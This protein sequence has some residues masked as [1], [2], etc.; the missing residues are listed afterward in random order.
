MEIEDPQAWI[1]VPGRRRL[2]SRP[3]NQQ[4]TPSNDTNTSNVVG[5]FAPGFNLPPEELPQNYCPMEN[6]PT[7]QGGHLP[8][9]QNSN[10][11]IDSKVTSVDQLNK[12]MRDNKVQDSQKPTLG[13]HTAGKDVQKETQ[14]SSGNNFHDPNHNDRTTPRSNKNFQKPPH[15]NIPTNDGTHRITIK[16]LPPDNVAGYKHDKNK[17]NEAIYNFVSD[18]LPQQYGVLY[19]WESED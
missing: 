15:P 3:P 14:N 18:I 8:S 19:R 16:W 10:D 13:R 6:K 4:H 1:P 2:K 17:M 7:D 11:A 12:M 5:S 9:I